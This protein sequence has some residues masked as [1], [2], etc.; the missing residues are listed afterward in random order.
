M[1]T[2]KPAFE[3]K[4]QASLIAA[5]L[6]R[7]P[8]SIADVA[9]PALDRLLRRCV[10]KD[11]ERR[12]E[13]A[14]DW[15]QSIRNA[16]RESDIVIVCLSRKAVTKEGFV[17]KEI[18]FALDIADEKPDGVRYI[19]LALFEKASS[20]ESVGDRYLSSSGGR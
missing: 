20:E 2:G 5:I 16:V 12:W 7:N 15:E 6:E 11:P 17:Q 1:L 19:I 8:P 9:P 13:S 3:G 18:R 14:D 4:S 10:A